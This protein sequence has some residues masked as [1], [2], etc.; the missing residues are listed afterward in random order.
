MKKYVLLHWN[1][2]PE[3]SKFY[4]I[5]QEEMTTEITSFLNEAHNKFINCAGWEDNRGL[6][7]LT[8]ALAESQ[9]VI[10]LTGREWLKYTTIFHKYLKDHTLP[11]EAEI[12]KVY[13]SGIIL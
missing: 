1:E 3:G 5:P 4:L 2:V 10:D 9:D 13:Y 6:K 8:V 11:I 12:T 7:F